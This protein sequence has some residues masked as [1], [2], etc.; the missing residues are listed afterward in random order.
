MKIE[1]DSIDG[2]AVADGS[3]GAN[4]ENRSTIRISVPGPF[5]DFQGILRC[6]IS[7]E[8]RDFLFEIV[9]L[10]GELAAFVL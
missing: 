8:S 1:I 4:L 9:D 6:E 3:M 2:K 10:V 5:D 7:D